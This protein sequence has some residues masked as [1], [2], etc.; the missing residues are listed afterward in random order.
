M[1]QLISIVGP[2][3]IGKTSFSISLA[4]Q[5]NCEIVSADSRQFFKEMAIG[6][7]KPDV[8]E[9]DGIPHHFVDFLS[10]NDPYTAGQFEKEAIAKI[11][12]IHQKTE[13]AIMVGGSG[14]YVNAVHDGMDDIPSDSELR[15]LL[16]NELKDRGIEPLQIEL[17]KLDPEH[18]EFMDIHNPQRLIRAIE[19]CR[20]SGKTYTSFRN[21]IN[22]TRPFNIIKIGLIADREIIYDRINQRVDLMIEAGLVE[23]V[24]SLHKLKSLNALQTVG[25][26][27]LFEH[28]EG[29]VTLDEAIENIKMNTRR[30]AKRQMTWFKKDKDTK[31]FDYKDQQQIKDYVAS[32]LK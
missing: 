25:Y 32:Q 4:K 15:D 14:L 26:R 21:K 19:V 11:E 30:F 16:N 8:T 13:V 3:A 12:E 28:F 22:K 6:T 9:M 29:N 24:K 5:Y 31:W 7:A 2:T 17:K 18:Y 1:K 10:V 27:E 20:L 23:E